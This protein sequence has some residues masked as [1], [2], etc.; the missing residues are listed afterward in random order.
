MERESHYA[1]RKYSDRL[2]G[3]NVQRIQRG[4][5]VKLR[6]SFPEWPRK[7]NAK[8]WTEVEWN[9]EREEEEGRARR[10]GRKNVEKGQTIP[11]YFIPHSR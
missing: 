4:L 6:G 1:F 7:G 8:G 11:R 2:A 9:G 10:A 3:L 5:G